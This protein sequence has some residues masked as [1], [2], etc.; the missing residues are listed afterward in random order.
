MEKQKQS[1]KK[2]CGFTR[3]NTM[4]RMLRAELEKNDSDDQNKSPKHIENK[5]KLHKSNKP[6]KK[7]SK[8][9]TN[10]IRPEIDSLPSKRKQSDGRQT[11]LRFNHELAVLENNNNTLKS[12]LA[13][14][15]ISL[16]NLIA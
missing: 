9:T 6:I 16:N 2:L 10:S 1:N 13:E 14:I 4:I 11:K 7:I 15:L 3:A 8:Q 5:N 12:Q